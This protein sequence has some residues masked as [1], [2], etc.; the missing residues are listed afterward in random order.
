MGDGGTPLA[1]AA[2]ERG[3]WKRAGALSPCVDGLGGGPI[4]RDGPGLGGGIIAIGRR[5][6]P[7][8]GT[9]EFVQHGLLPAD[10]VCY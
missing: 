8:G 7:G 10:N 5:R 9:T 2:G 4:D 6:R 1:P 3:S